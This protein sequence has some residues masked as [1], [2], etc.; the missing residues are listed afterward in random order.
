MHRKVN[1]KPLRHFVPL[2][3]LGK[4]LVLRVAGARKPQR[5]DPTSPCAVNLMA[6]ERKID[7]DLADARDIADDCFRH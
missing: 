5:G 2:T 4:D 3:A 7:N 6:L 1:V